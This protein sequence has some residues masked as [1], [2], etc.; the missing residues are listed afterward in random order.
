[1]FGKLTYAPHKVYIERKTKE[2]DDFGNFVAEEISLSYVC[3]CRC[4]DANVRDAVSVNGE[5]FIPSYHIVSEKPLNN[6]DFVKVYDGEEI[7][8]EGKIINTKKY[9]FFKI[10]EAW[11]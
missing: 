11:I 5:T 3:K 8:A 6:G 7:R 4:D 9:N 10:Y 2:Y 1:M